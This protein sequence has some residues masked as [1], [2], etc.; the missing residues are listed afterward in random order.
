MKTYFLAFVKDKKHFI[1][2]LKINL[3]REPEELH[4]NIP[5]AN[6][7]II[8]RDSLELKSKLFIQQIS[9]DGLSSHGL[10]TKS[11]R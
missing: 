11:L 4:T 6:Q 3:K 10:V 8:D 2:S 9:R 7:R 5:I 1:I